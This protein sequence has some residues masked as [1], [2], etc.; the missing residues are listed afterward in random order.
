M[1]VLVQR[2]LVFAIISLA[3]ML[4]SR[5]YAQAASGATAAAEPPEEVTVRGRRTLTQYRLEL[6]KA[7]EDIF[8]I[9]NEANE[10]NDTDIRCRAEQPTGSRM[11]QTVCRSKAENEADSAAARNF[12][13]SL[14]AGAGEF[15]TYTGGGVGPPGGAQINAAEG[16]RQAQGE[17]QSGEASALAAFETEWNR[18]LREDRQL[19]RAVVRYAELEDEYNAARGAT[20]ASAEPAVM[21]VLE[22]P[23]EVTASQP[24]APPCEAT[25]LTEYQ[26]R[27]NV[28][29]V[30]GRVSIASCPAGTA[31][32]F[33]L[34][35]R[36]RDDNGEIRPIEFNETWQR[37][38][39]E[40]HPFNADYPIGDN[41]EL[42]NVRVRGLTCTCAAPAL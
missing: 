3:A 42:L 24:N 1:R 6:E 2:P 10:G 20:G 13:S 14:F 15:K 18:L 17:G 11:P 41:V 28:A 21:V 38:D 37:P 32:S 4:S 31:G 39:A 9:Y 12:L 27:N 34:V 30:T 8:R 29:R 36:V 26:Q 19:Y 16:M 25:T 5:A 7:R 35:A 40:D 33:T 22:E 23:A